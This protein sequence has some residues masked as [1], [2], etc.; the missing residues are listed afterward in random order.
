MHGVFFEREGLEGIMIVD[1]L[2][3]V[4]LPN[5]AV[6]AGAGLGWAA[7]LRQLLEVMCCQNHFLY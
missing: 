3:S 6:V 5:G 4:K 7:L 1:R 2:A